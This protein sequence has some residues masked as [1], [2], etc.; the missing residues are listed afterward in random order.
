MWKRILLTLLLVIVG[1]AAGGLAYLYFRKP[2]MALPAAI[3]VEMTPERIARGRVLFQTI[4]DCDG[5]HSERDFTRVGGPVVTSGRGRGTVLSSIMNGLPGTVVAPNITPD[6]ETGIG[7]WTDGEKIRA[8]RDG[9]D[10]D[11][12]ALFPMMPYSGYRNMSDEDVQS[13]VAYLNSLPPIRN[14]L[15]RTKLN[16]PVNL[17]IKSVPQPAGVVPA[18]DRSDKA[19]YGQYLVAIG[20][21]ADCHTPTRKGQ[22][23]PEK[24][25]AGGQ[26]FATTM[27]T[28]VSANIT[29]DIETG[30]GKWSEEFFLKKFYDY[31]EYAAG[32]AP[33]AAGPEAFTLM[34]W[35]GFS[36][37]PPEDLA[38][39]Y[40]WLRTAK[41]VHNSVETHPGAPKK[42][43]QASAR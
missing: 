27:G 11:D 6:P 17:F 25:L 35:L 43:A 19:K 13:V 4:A 31:K 41:P 30:I 28:V 37:L 21:C 16:F 24:E 32:G 10:R 33:K 3:K 22:P 9:V 12:R 40:A 1:L 18:A 2:A 20:G 38:A 7:S 5:C 34:P 14:P 36:Q 42:T 8:I 15:P 26:V 29:P 23:I 39:V